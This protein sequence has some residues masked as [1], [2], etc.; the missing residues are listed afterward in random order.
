MAGVRLLG[1]VQIVGARGTTTNIAPDTRLAIVLGL[2]GWN[3]NETVSTESLLDAA[4]PQRPP[5]ARTALHGQI[6]KLRRLFDEADVPAAVVTSG[7]GY[8]LEIDGATLDLT[9]FLASARRGRALADAD[10]AAALAE[11]RCAIEL[12]GE[13]F[14]GGGDGTPLDEARRT[15]RLELLRVEDAVSELELALGC[16]DPEM[17]R[18]RV[19]AEPLREVRWEQLVRSLYRGSRQA[20]ALRACAQVREVLREELGLEP[21]PALRAIEEQVLLHDPVLLKRV[22]R[23]AR[24]FDVASTDFIGRDL[25]LDSLA[26]SVGNRQIVTMTGAGGI[27]K[28]RLALRLLDRVAGSFPGGLWFVP[29][30]STTTEREIWAQVRTVTGLAGDEEQLA[31]S[32]GSGGPALLVLDNC[33]QVREAAAAVVL[34]LVEASPDLRL[35]ATARSTLG[36]NDELVLSIG[37]LAAAARPGET[38]SDARRLFE[39]CVVSRTGRGPD[40][41]D[42]RD[43]EAIDRI[44]ELT[45]GLPLAI[46]LAAGRCDAG[47]PSAVLQLLDGGLDAYGRRVD[48]QVNHRSMRDTIEWSV[49]LLDADVADAMAAL[50]VLRGGFDLSAAAAL[51]ALD[52]SSAL[53]ALTALADASLVAAVGAGRWSILP[54]IQRWGRDHLA[55]TGEDVVVAGRHFAHFAAA[56]V[57]LGVGLTSG[58]RG[59]VA[60]HIDDVFPDLVAAVGFALD[61]DDHER[62]MQL[63]PTVIRIAGECGLHP[64]RLPIEERALEVTQSAESRDRGLLIQAASWRA[65]W[66]RDRDIADGLATECRRLGDVLDDDLTRMR[67]WMSTGNVLGWLDGRPREASEAFETA[68]A[69]ARTL[70]DATTANALGSVGYMQGYLGAHQRALE[71]GD[72]LAELG[73]LFDIDQLRFAAHSLRGWAYLLMGKLDD[74]EPHLEEQ[75]RMAEAIGLMVLLPASQARLARLYI[76]QDDHDRADKVLRMSLEGARRWGAHLR[77]ADTTTTL[78]LLERRRRRFTE[79]QGWFVASA[80]HSLTTLDRSALAGLLLEQALL[81]EAVGL[82][83]AAEQRAAASAVLRARTGFVPAATLS[84]EAGPLMRVCGASF[85]ARSDFDVA[86]VAAR[87]MEWRVFR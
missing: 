66:Q 14:G 69:F 1:D 44:C 4:W 61:D 38:R 3:A 52:E 40:V 10:A 43:D 57:D 22:E 86:R 2:L 59:E 60:A 24:R 71:I 76:E 83:D 47:S 18:R 30:G 74:A 5:T 67:G 87:P 73:E 81:A 42:D 9:A 36:V 33:E 23:P 12:W 54:P 53:R 45:G 39:A 27:G 78:G 13:P 46:E 8:R 15:L 55:S 58:R 26:R 7:A 17:L 49:S 56:A 79:A 21:G 34:R 80:R 35:L 20:E 11:L 51:T 85:D 63:A 77:L 68:L 41:V 72:E 70:G 62:T 32:L 65:L 75:V 64:G 31:R 19:E 28:T 16:D 29:C 50:C 84:A 6:A 82:D 25:E 48:A 37:P